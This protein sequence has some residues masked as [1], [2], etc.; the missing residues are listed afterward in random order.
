MTACLLVSTVISI[1][2]NTYSI[3][4]PSLPPPPLPTYATQQWVHYAASIVAGETVPNCEICHLWIA[5]TI[6]QDIA[7]GRNP[8]ALHPG[9][10]HGYHTPRPEHLAAVEAALQKQGCLSVPTCAYLGN[11]NDYRY[12]SASRLAQDVSCHLVG[13]RHG[14][15]VCV[16]PADPPARARLPV[17]Q[18]TGAGPP[19]R[20]RA[21]PASPP[22]ETNTATTAKPEPRRPASP[23]PARPRQPGHACE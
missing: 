20:A 4:P 23:T 14:A 12:W 10:W 11:L 2:I 8:W 9:R 19:A 15:T 17:A 16:P 22:V 7:G 1:T 21:G 6:K 5:C 3:P 18:Q 13:N